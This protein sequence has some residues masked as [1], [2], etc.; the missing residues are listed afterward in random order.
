MFVLRPLNCLEKSRILECLL[1]C[2]AKNY[3]LSHNDLHFYSILSAL[4]FWTL[5]YTAS[6]P[7]STMK[8]VYERVEHS[9][10]HSKRSST[11]NFLKNFI[12]LSFL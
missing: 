5:Q 7:S 6:L 4:A 12:L 2:I 9:S 11:R 10:F 1:Y 3:H 8:H